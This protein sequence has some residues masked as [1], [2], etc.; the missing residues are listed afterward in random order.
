MKTPGKRNSVRDLH[1]T[2]LSCVYVRISKVQNP[3]SPTFAPTFSLTTKQT[4]RIAFD[5]VTVGIL[6]WIS[7]RRFK[8]VSHFQTQVQ[9]S[10]EQEIHLDPA[11][12]YRPGTRSPSPL[13][14]LDADHDGISMS[15]ETVRDVDGSTT[16]ITHTHKDSGDGKADLKV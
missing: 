11:P 6:C 10:V 14:M 16:P 1:F 2:G 5:T 7:H 4:E 3:S 9:V 8:P 12:E 15:G 13:R